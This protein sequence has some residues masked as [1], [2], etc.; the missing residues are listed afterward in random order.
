MAT[1]HAIIV[2]YFSNIA[3]T[4]I[5]LKSFYRMDLTEIQGAF[6]NNKVTPTLVLESHEADLGDSNVMQTVKNI[7]FAFTIYILPKTGDYD[8]QNAKLDESEIIGLKVIARMR[9]D[10]TIPG[11]FLYNKFK[12]A[13]V[14]YSKVGPVFNEELYG[15]RF[16]GNIKAPDPL[17]V[18]PT[19]WT[20]NP[21]ICN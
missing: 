17:I 21:T 11:H 2:N 1:T 14:N 6:R 12:S 4:L 19:D 3:D 9:H 18:N 16:S 10:A 8:D 20:D 7:S 5:D 15:F 13:E